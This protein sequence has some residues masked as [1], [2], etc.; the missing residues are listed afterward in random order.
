ML[1][2]INIHTHHFSGEHT[3]PRAF[4]IHPWDAEKVDISTLDE[5]GL[6]AQE[7]AIG[8]IGLDFAC[9]VDREQQKRLFCRQLEIAQ[10]LGKPVVLHCVK[11]FEPTLN[12]LSSYSLKAVIFHGFIGS[13]EQ[14]EAALKQGYYLSFGHR[15]RHSPKS[16]EALRAV[17][18]NRIFVETDESDRTIVEMY[19]EIAALKGVTTNELLA[20]TNENYKTI[21]ERE[22]I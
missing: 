1:R 14:A 2:F 22:H 21:F 11:A 8:E 6:F 7:E 3:E 12:L 19:E 13:K 4:G 5:C 10:R 16:I 17:P 9:E 15:T 20:A 18:L